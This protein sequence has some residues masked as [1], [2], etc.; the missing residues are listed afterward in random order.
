MHTNNVSGV[1][2]AISYLRLSF[3]HGLGV[4]DAIDESPARND[5]KAKNYIIYYQTLKAGIDK[6]ETTILPLRPRSA[7][8]HLL[9]T[10]PP[11]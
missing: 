5:D 11:A 1:L 7:D 2:I 3:Q 10:S 4:Y 8:L 6:T 9:E